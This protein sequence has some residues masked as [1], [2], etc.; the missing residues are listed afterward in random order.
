MNYVNT[1]MAHFGKDAETFSIGLVNEYDAINAR[2]EW[3]IAI[4]RSTL[5]T[6][7]MALLNADL[8][9]TSPSATSDLITALY[10][11]YEVQHGFLE[12]EAENALEVISRIKRFIDFTNEKGLQ[13]D[14][15]FFDFLWENGFFLEDVS[16]LQEAQ[17]DF[18]RRLFWDSE[19]DCLVDD[20]EAIYQHVIVDSKSSGTEVFLFAGEYRLWAAALVSMKEIVRSGKLIKKCSNCGKYFFPANRSDE[21]YCDNQSPEAPEMTCKEYGTRRLWYERQKEDEL[22]TLSRKIA[23]AKGMLAK[24]NPDRPEYAAYYEYF[25]AQRRIWIKAV[26]DGTKTPEEYKKWLLYMKEHNTLKAAGISNNG[27]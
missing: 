13:Y 17:E 11:S 25:K 19:N 16:I 5:G 3:T 6:L 26:K 10:T 20:L 1:V 21:I 15:V 8:T 22:A 4:G 7:L 18:D 2:E 14:A 24:R 23:S 12:T 9:T 27:E